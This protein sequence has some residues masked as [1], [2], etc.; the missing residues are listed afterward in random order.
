MKPI[1][2]ASLFLRA[3]ADDEGS[4]HGGG[5]AAPDAATALAA[6]ANPTLTMTQRL[7]IA[8]KALQGIDPTNQ[9]A[10]VQAELATAQQ[11][12]A[13]KDAELTTA[14]AGLETAQQQITAL[15]ADV[16]ALETSTAQIAQENTDLKAKEQDL[17]KRA[18]RKSR[19]AVA[20]LGFPAN[21]LPAKTPVGASQ[22]E[23]LADLDAKAAATKDPVEKGRLAGLRFNLMFPAQGGPN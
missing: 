5:A 23:Q 22:E 16:Q 8:A 13:A 4:D 2:F 1:F 20:A 18:E 15:Q 6:I 21:Q 11:A 7:S 3:P 17:E 19:E 9:L 12:L 10:A 14:K